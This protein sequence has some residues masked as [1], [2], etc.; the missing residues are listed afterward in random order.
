MERTLMHK[1]WSP[2]FGMSYKGVQVR[3][4]VPGTT[5][6]FERDFSAV[7]P[8]RHHIDLQH[9]LNLRNLTR[10]I[11]AAQQ[12]ATQVKSVK[13]AQC[14]AALVTVGDKWLHLDATT[15]MTE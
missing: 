6:A 11:P 1:G 12:R 7:L 13:A 14:Q 8:P 15:C 3:P 2:R 5:F 9:L 4:L 10:G